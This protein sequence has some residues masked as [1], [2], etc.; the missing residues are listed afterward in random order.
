MFQIP[1]LKLYP[2][3]VHLFERRLMHLSAIVLVVSL[4]VAAGPVSAKGSRASVSAATVCALDT[5]VPEFTVEIRVRDK[6]SG[7]AIARVAA[8]SITALAKTERGNWRNQTLFGSASKGGLNLPVPTRIGPVPFS[9]CVPDGSGVY[10]VIN[11]IIAEAKGLNAMAET[12]YGRLNEDTMDVEDQRT[13][14]NMCSDDPFTEDVVEP[15]GI[16]LNA[17]DIANIEAACAAL[18]P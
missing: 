11:P 15:S 17:E 6:T 9:L 5:S 16:K 1:T 8:W 2:M 14:M 12:T 13:I 4:A 18:N 7:D 3:L 10:H